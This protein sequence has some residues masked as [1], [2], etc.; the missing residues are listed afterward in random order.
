MMKGTAFGV[1]V[2]IM[3]VFA[4]GIMFI[5]MDAPFLTLTNT[6]LDMLPAENNASA[7]ESINRNKAIWD[8]LPVIIMFG[9]IIYILFEAQRREPEV[10]Y[11]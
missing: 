5:I 4:G 2:G 3:I 8:F 1:F 6:A 7:I 9:G 11:G 10:V